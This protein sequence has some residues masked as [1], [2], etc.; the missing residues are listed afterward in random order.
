ME[1]EGANGTSGSSALDVDITGSTRKSS[2]DTDKSKPESNWYM[3]LL[4]GVTVVLGN[5]FSAVWIACFH[6]FLK[7]DGDLI[8]K[9]GSAAVTRKSEI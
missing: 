1:P 2:G 9:G 6:A 4:F 7:S 5:V 8:T 3:W